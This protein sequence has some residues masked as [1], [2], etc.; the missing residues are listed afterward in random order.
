MP[1]QARGEVIDPAEVQV[2]HCVQRCVRRAFLCGEDPF[3]GES[4]EHRREWIRQRLEFLASVFGI[5]C[6]TYTVMS[7]H[8][9]LVL[10]SRP[11]VVVTWSDEEVARRWLRLFPQRREKDGSSAEPTKPELQMI[12]N[13]P[14]LLAERRRRLSD[15]SWWMRCTAENI[16]RRSNRE[17]QVTGHFW[18]GRY[19]AQL[20]LDEA[21]LLACSAYVDLNPVRAA[22]AQTPERS[23]FTGAKDRIDDLAERQDRRRMSTHD[24]ERS[25]R[26]RKSGW[27]SPI[28][29]NEL[30]DA[31][32]ADVDTSGRRASKKGF[33]SISMHRY[34]ELLDWTGRQLREGKRG[35]IPSHLAPILSRIGLDSHAWCDLVRQFGR[36][37]KR[38]AGTAEHMAEEASRRGVGW[39][40]APG[41]PLG[42]QSS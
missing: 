31:I 16:A 14:E 35:A 8:L 10:R 37:F 42:L 39:L 38:A 17:D 34:L 36:V 21:S 26:R 20:L 11:D 40:H 32:G 19:K 4:F 33:L 6:L 3:S 29:I 13:D 24:W 7:N 25:R 1:R 30:D 5:D 27:M 15:L 18:E 22:I 12:V 28:E 9:H 2:V 23:H 41:N